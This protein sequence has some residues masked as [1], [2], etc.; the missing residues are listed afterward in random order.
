MDLVSINPSESLI[1]TIKIV[2]IL[3]PINIDNPNMIKSNKYH[4]H[5][6][7]CIPI[8]LLVS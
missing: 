1:N 2:L 6:T 4:L 8:I 3:S 5:G 7:I